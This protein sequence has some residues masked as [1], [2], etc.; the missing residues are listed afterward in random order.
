MITTEETPQPIK[1]IPFVLS[2]PPEEILVA[3]QV[4]Q[5]V[6]AVN[7]LVPESPLTIKLDYYLD[8][9]PMICGMYF[10]GADPWSIHISPASCMTRNNYTFGDDELSYH[11]YPVDMSMFGVAIHEFAHLLAY[12]FFPDILKEFKH[13]FPKKRLYLTRYTE[14]DPNEEL[15]ELTRLYIQNPLFL[16]MI[17]IQSYKFLKSKFKSPTPCSH[18]QA[19]KFYIEFPKEIRERLSSEWGIDYNVET[20]KFVNNLNSKEFQ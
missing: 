2:N 18:K 10:E 6:L 5:N 3:H 8:K 9:D 15:T 20:E 7:N 16:K 1:H 19:Y 12:N 17:D 13:E 4:M 14:S 11:G